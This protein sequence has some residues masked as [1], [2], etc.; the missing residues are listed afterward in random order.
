MKAFLSKCVPRG[1]GKTKAS[2]DAR[3]DQM[4]LDTKIVPFGEI[5]E[6]KHWNRVGSPE[7][8][9]NERRIPCVVVT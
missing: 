9:A 4:Q 6:A 8:L 2:R 5:S 3:H 7:N 1:G